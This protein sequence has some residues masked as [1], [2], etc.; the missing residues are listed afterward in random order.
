MTLELFI[1][2][3]SC[4]DDGKAEIKDLVTDAASEKI[5]VGLSVEFV[6]NIVNGNG[7]YSVVSSDEDLVM[8]TID[9][10]KVTIKGIKAGE[11]IV[12]ISDAAKQ[13]VRLTVVVK[14]PDVPLS[15]L[16]VDKKD[17]T[18]KVNEQ[19]RIT[20]KSGNGDYVL[21]NPDEGVLK[22][23]VV[24]NE[25]VISGIKEG[26]VVLTLSDREGESLDITVK[27]EKAGAQEDTIVGTIWVTDEKKLLGEM[28]EGTIESLTRTLHFVDEESMTFQQ[29]LKTKDN[30]Q[31]SDLVSLLYKYT[32]PGIELGEFS[33]NGYDLD[34]AVRKDGAIVLTFN[35]GKETTELTFKRKE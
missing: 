25:I 3:I 26:T 31:S 13:E 34:K 23:E 33:L 30:S 15:I 16:E 8:A 1:G 20:I 24:D 14:E 2:F 10:G 11:A 5:E 22:A 7:S 4:S 28:D 12:T 21:Q 9:G 29:I 35:N 6:V 27:V 17:V 32:N 18:V 19:A